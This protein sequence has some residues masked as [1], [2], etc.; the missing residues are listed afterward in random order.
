[1]RPLVFHLAD[2]QM[3]E[4]FRAFFKRNDWQFKLGCA[5]FDFDPDDERDL[6]RIGG[7]TDPGLYDNA[8]ENLRTHQRTHE[9][10]IVVIDAQFPGTPGTD[11]VAA[12]AVRER[13][14]GNLHSS[15]WTNDRIEVVVIQPMLEAWLWSESDHV[16]AIFGVARYDDLRTNLVAQGVWEAGANKPS[17]FKEA[18]AIAARI[19]HQVSD[20]ALFRRVFTCARTLN[21]CAEPGFNR[22]RTTLQA[23]FPVEGGAA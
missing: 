12:A 4:G 16:S 1:M 5:R 19:K 23:W 9:R 18:T 3:Y 15:G 20:A 8:H 6:F 10:A 14:L 22:L 17:N 11:D 21:G 13:I 2:R 7:C